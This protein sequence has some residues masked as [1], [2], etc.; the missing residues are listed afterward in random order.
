MSPEQA[1]GQAVDKR[2]DIWAF[3]C[4]LFEILAGHR[5]FR[6]ET[7]SDT[8]AVVL[9]REPA[10][11]QLP[12]DTPPA[13]RRLLRRCLDKDHK[14]RLRDIGDARLEIADAQSGPQ[15]DERAA[16]AGAGLGRK[17][18]WASALAVPV[19]AAALAGSWILR[20]ASSA[21]ELRLEIST[22][23]SSDASLAISPD[24]LKVIFTGVSAGVPQLW[25]RALDSSE[26]RPLPGTERAS[27]PFWS[28]D[29]RSVGFF[30]ESKLKRIEIDDGSVK[31]LASPAPAPVGGAWSSDGIILFSASPGKPILRISDEGGEASPVT[32]FESSQHRGHFYPTFLPDGR[33]F[34]F[35][36][37]GSAEASGVY[38]GHL[39]GLDTKRLLAADAPAAYSATGQLLFVRGGQLL[40]QAF[41]PD[42][43]EVTGTPV[44]VV[45]QVSRRTALSVSAAGPIVY[46]T[47]AG[48][49]GQRQLV[50]VD[51]SG[52]ETGKVVYPDTVALGP[53]L[54]RDGR[55]VGVFR[56]MN[57]NTDIWE[58]DTVSRAWDRITV[59]SG[60]DIYPLWSADGHHIVFGSRRGEMDLYRKTL[61]TP[62]G[63]GEERLLS[64]P[65]VKF[66][67]DLSRDGRFLLY[68][69]LHGG[70]TDMWALPLDGDRKPL[71]IVQTEFDDRLGQFSPD[72]KWVAYQSNRSGRFEI[73]L[74]RFPGPG[75]DFRVSTEG[76]AQVRWN[77]TGKELFYIAAD[78]R[79]TAVPI[80]FSAD[81]E[82]AEPGQPVPLFGT[83]LG[84]AA[85]NTNR[86]QYA[87]SP[88]GQSFVLNSTL[89]TA[90][91]SPITVIL[92]WK[93][94]R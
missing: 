52:N 15:A 93:P 47:T 69:I 63:S 4:V 22:P 50:W 14:R 27:F 86:Q 66:P 35:F 29:S 43:L 46:R 20:P 7:I 32:R 31:T 19:L 30:A 37:T 61:G 77:P 45:K 88:D 90:G 54:S 41:D 2:A 94:P 16:P 40:A 89:D 60:D 11:D 48:D 71:A 33:Q 24:G 64:T 25:L 5:A 81:G 92:N 57:G 42:R 74:R 21:P 34:L 72:G 38:I 3:G 55:R 75:R 82:T 9:E 36:V 84:S 78:D 39:G 62:P 13:I 44:P 49:S 28:P 6:G 17:L 12:A 59:D 87:V 26:A 1:R 10:W 83:N 91:T 68:D 80:R 67:M 73:Y 23:P 53:S 56:Q 65:G 70:G 76:G 58:Y 18:V 8:I 51:R 79:L 85:P